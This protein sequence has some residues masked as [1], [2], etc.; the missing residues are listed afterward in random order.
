M[1]QVVSMFSP[2]N[3]V[4]TDLFDEKLALARKYG[5]THTYKMPHEHASTMDIVG[6][7]FLM[8]LTL[9]S[10][11]CWKVTA[12]LMPS[13]PQHRMDVLSCMVVLALVIR[14]SI[15]LKFIKASGHI[16]YRA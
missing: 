14:Q 8:V 11:A 13:T 4:V 9:S 12:W 5:A 6:A 16:F 2:K 3:L 10:L 1:T 7:D 15:S